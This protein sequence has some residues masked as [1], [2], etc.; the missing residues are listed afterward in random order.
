MFVKG[1][2]KSK[3]DFWYKVKIELLKSPNHIFLYPL[4][5]CQEGWYVGLG[6]EGVVWGWGV[7]F[8]IP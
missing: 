6:Q 7:L 5:M 2:K 8:E 4:I 3:I 1:F